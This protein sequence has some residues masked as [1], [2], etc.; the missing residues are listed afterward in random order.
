MSSSSE[1]TIY[2][3]FTKCWSSLLVPWEPS[4]IE[5]SIIG[6]RK[7]G[8]E[9]GSWNGAWVACRDTHGKIVCS[10]FDKNMDYIGHI[11]DWE[12][13]LEQRDSFIKEGWEPMTREDIRDTSGLYK[14]LNDITYPYAATSGT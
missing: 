1:E 4:I 8:T 2:K 5:E 7:P 3:K 12:K 9:S 10:F 13:I 6:Y 14:N 11:T